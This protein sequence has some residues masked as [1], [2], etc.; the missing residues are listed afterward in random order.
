MIQDI[1]KISEIHEIDLFNTIKR[2]SGFH[3]IQIITGHQSKGGEF[4]I[5]FFIGLR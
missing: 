1:N 3:A 2:I 4:D 5:V